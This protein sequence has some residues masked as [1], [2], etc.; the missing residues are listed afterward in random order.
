MRLKIKIAGGLLRKTGKDWPCDKPAV[1]QLRF[2]R[3]CIIEHHQ[4]DKLGMLGRKI[5]SERN[6]VLSLFISASRINFL[7]GSRFSSNG[8]A[9]YGRGGG[10]PVVAHYASKRVTN[11]SGGFSRNN[12]SQRYW[13]K[14]TDGFALRCSDRFHDPRH[15]QFATVS[16]RRHCHRH[17]QWCHP[18]LVPHGDTSDGDFAPRLRRPNEPV[19]LTGQLNSGALAEPETSNVFVK[20]LFAHAQSEFGRSDVARFDKN[21]AHAQIRKGAMIVQCSAAKVPEAVLT[22][23]RRIRPQLAFVES[24]GGCYDLE[25]RAR[26]HHVDDGPVFHLIGPGFRAEV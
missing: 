3:V 9:W 16:N 21:I 8:K 10:C 13:R 12:L 7:R 24:S 22:K 11:I 23:D 15:D 4:T 25:S 14:R 26:F 1:I 17:L 2:A 6:D 20:L 5:A 19:D 18:D